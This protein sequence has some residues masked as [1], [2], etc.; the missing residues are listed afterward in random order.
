MYEAFQKLTTERKNEIIQV[1]I[2]EFGA[3][4]YSAASTNQIIERA[5]ISKGILFHYFG[6]KKHLYLFIVNHIASFFIQLLEENIQRVQEE[7]FFERIKQVIMVQLTIFSPYPIEYRMLM[8]AFSEPPVELKKEMQEMYLSMYRSFNVLNTTFYSRYM[9]PSKLRKNI[10][11]EQAVELIN[12]LFDQ[13]TQKY[14]KLYRGKP[15]ELLENNQELMET[16]DSYID[17]LK[18]GIYGSGE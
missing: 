1:C 15:K 2:E 14:I 16:L 12:I 8:K 6:S 11:L 18:Y 7:D 5:G 4:G 3:R 10:N 9:E 13:L 17:V